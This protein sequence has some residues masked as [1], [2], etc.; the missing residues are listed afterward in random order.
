MNRGEAMKAQTPPGLTE[1]HTTR[2]GA[3]SKGTGKL[4]NETPLTTSPSKV[5]SSIREH[6]TPAQAPKA[7]Q[8]AVMKRNAH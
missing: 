4:R 6:L 5:G 7:G 2:T 1:L 8:T 3:V